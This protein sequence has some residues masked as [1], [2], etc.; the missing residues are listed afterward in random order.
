MYGM[1]VLGFIFLVV[2]AILG[3]CIVPALIIVMWKKGKRTSLIPVFTGMLSFFISVFILEN[4]FHSI[5]IGHDGPIKSFLTGNGIIYG[6]YGGLAA[7]LFEETARFVSF[8]LLKRH[9]ARKTAI[10][11]GLG[12]GGLEVIIILGISMA[13]NI[14]TLITV[15]SVGIDTMASSLSPGQAQSLRETI[16][17]IQSITP[18]T[19]IAALIERLAAMA[20]QISLSVFVFAA[21]RREMFI[22]YPVAILMHAFLDF[23]AGLYQ[24]GIIPNMWIIEAIVVLIAM[25]YAF[26]ASKLYRN[27]NSVML[28][29]N[30]SC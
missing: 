13:F 12:H 27:L 8:K 21:A 30:A 23:P 6:I 1:T 14:V 18:F 29:D 9:T 11:Y 3:C 10:C 28:D 17:A 19:C 2:T 20:A 26:A 4:L 16:N 5:M 24:S 7:G 25:I 22:L 15:N